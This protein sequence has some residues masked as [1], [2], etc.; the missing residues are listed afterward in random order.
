M[1][2]IH[3]SNRPLGHFA[4]LWFMLRATP[5]AGRVGLEL[6]GGFGVGSLGASPA[7]ASEEA[8]LGAPWF[9]PF[10]RSSMQVVCLSMQEHAPS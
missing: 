1:Q 5:Q 6:D 10:T 7:S 3:A 2:K 8:R 9:A 4:M